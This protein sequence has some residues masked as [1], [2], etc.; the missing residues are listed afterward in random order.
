M[1]LTAVATV[2]ICTCN[3]CFWAVLSRNSKPYIS[4]HGVV[5]DHNL[6]VVHR[7]LTP[8]PPCRSQF[9]LC[10]FCGKPSDT[11]TVVLLYPVNIILSVSSCQYCPTVASFSSK[12]DTA[13]IRSTS[14]Q[15]LGTKHYPSLL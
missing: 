12:L 7:L 14:M 9:V 11:G 10:G 4:L 3:A 5:L 15:I 8:D 13:L 6:T 1:A 2:H